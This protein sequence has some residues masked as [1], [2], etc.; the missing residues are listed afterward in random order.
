LLPQIH[1][2]LAQTHDSKI[3]YD[4]MKR[5]KGCLVAGSTAFFFIVFV[6]G[7]N[8]WFS[9]DITTKKLAVQNPTTYDFNSSLADVH[10]ALRKKVVKC[11]GASIEF[12][13]DAIFGRPVLLSV[14]NE[15]DAYIHN[16]HEPIGAS[17]VYFSRGTPLPYICEFQIHLVPISPQETRVV[18]IARNPEVIAGLSWW[19]LHGSPANIYKDVKPTSIEEYKILLELGSSLG[20]TGM[21]KLLLPTTE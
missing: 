15:N 13:A 6:Y 8:P 21:P 9:P 4:A 7:L 2:F 12:K 1:Q 16:F 11:C 19:G 17:A 10:E 14:G 20:A 18:V 5:N 3:C